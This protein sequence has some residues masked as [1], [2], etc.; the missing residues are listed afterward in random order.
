[1]KRKKP[2]ILKKVRFITKQQQQ[3]AGQAPGKL[4]FIGEQKQQEA[5]IELIA[6][7]E[8][9]FIKTNLSSIKE[10]EN[11]K[12]EYKNIWINID[13][14]HDVKLINSIGLYFNIHTLIL[15]D[16]VHTG[17]RPRVDVDENHIFTIIKMM[18]LDVSTHMLDAEQVSM[19][20]TKNILLTFQEKDGDIFEP[21]RERISKSNTRVRKLSLTYLKYSL[22]DAIV[23]NYNFLME[24]FGAKVEELE[25]KILLQPS[26][27]TLQEINLTKI[28]LNYFRKAIKPARE[29]LFSFKEFKTNLIDKE[30][31]L[32]F[33]DLID[34]IQRASDSVDH[35]K[36]MLSEQLTVYSTNVN[37]R[38]NDIMKI[39]TIFSAVFIPITFIA[40]IYGTNFKHIPELEY[41][42]GYYI[43]WGV[44]LLTAFSM[45]GYFKYKKWF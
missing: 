30:D 24:I 1:M 19:Y 37:N 32:F 22:L 8:N 29:V 41:Q 13:G 31:Q 3:T 15:E 14:L 25:D 36:S 20:L 42:N 18:S 39:L 43:M 16:I 6:Y 11:Y 40:G 5:T 2:Q 38:L 9:K 35:Y 33:N 17:Q 34:L 45:L 44:I 7:D 27:D 26:K 28:E 23:D 10:I 12:N 4:I 21:V